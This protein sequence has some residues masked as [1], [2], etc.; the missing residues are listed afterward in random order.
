MSL[1]A[2]SLIAA[3]GVFF[4]TSANF[5]A[6]KDCLLSA[7]STLFVSSVILAGGVDGLAV[8]VAS[9][10]LAAFTSS[11]ALPCSFA[12]SVNHFLFCALPISLLTFAFAGASVRDSRVHASR[13]SRL[14]P[15]HCPEP[16]TPRRFS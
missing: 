14:R 4:D 8:A 7:T 11:A 15:R 2:S 16:A 13:P 3:G 6:C 10:S 5:C 9:S 12:E 1:T